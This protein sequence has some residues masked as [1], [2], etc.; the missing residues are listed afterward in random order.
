M[1]LTRLEKMWPTHTAAEIAKELGVPRQK[2]Y[3]T[4]RSIG[5]DPKGQCKEPE[6]A[7][8]SEK[9]IE[10]LTKLIREKWSDEE[11]RSRRQVGRR[12]EWTLREVQ[13][14]DYAFSDV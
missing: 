8:P 14:S 12:R 5:L 7:D 1:D 9:E 10:A 2:V 6:T 11:E 13:F 4:A 3:R